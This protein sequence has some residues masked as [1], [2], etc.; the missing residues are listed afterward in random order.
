MKSFRSLVCLP[1]ILTVVA[2]AS[3]PR[4]AVVVE[5]NL[6]DSSATAAT[7]IVIDKVGA[8]QSKLRNLANIASKNSLDCKSNK[9]RQLW[10][11]E[12]AAPPHPDYQ[13]GQSSVS[14]RVEC[15]DERPNK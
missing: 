15:V 1:A 13:D 9:M 2:C 4:K 8:S 11:P 14:L 5:I 3:T 6:D 12:N 10:L 7:I